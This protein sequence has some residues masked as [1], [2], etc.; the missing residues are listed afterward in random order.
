[1][2]KKKKSRRPLDQSVIE[3]TLTLCGTNEHESFNRKKAI[4]TI[5]SHQRDRAYT[6]EGQTRYETIAT[7]RFQSG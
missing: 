6:R 2:K 4:Q 1:L 5:I 7:S 3:A